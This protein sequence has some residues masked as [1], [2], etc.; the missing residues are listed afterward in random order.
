MKLYAGTTEQFVRDAMQHRIAEKLAVEY[1]AELGHKPG[2]AEYTSWQNSL[3]SLGWLVDHA[4]LKDHGII[5]EYQL[6]LSS[7]RLDAMLT[8]HQTTATGPRNA[9]IIEPLKVEA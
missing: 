4:G 9:V 6:P 8:G 1:K 3:T 2:A 5:L 7:L